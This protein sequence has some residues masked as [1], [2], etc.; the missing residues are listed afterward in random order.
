M[1][2]KLI[3]V[4]YLPINQVAEVRI[5]MHEATQERHG[6]GPLAEQVEEFFFQ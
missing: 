3:L 1:V 6:T 4:L 2:S 5:E